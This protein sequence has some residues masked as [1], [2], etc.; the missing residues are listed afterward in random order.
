MKIGIFTSATLL[1]ITAIATPIWGASSIA[2]GDWDQGTTWDGGTPPSQAS[3]GGNG[4]EVFVNSNINV[5]TGVDFVS[6]STID[7]EGNPVD[8][9]STT[10]F[11]T[12]DAALGSSLTIQGGARVG[13]K[14]WVQITGVANATVDVL[15]GG[16]FVSSGI[17]NNDGGT[18]IVN[19]EPGG[20]LTFDSSIHPSFPDPG[21]YRG[22]INGDMAAG[23]SNVFN[24]RG[25]LD[26]SWISNATVGGGNAYNLIDGGVINEVPLSGQ[27]IGLNS[28]NPQPSGSISYNA[29]T[30]SGTGGTIT[31]AFGGAGIT[32]VPAGLTVDIADQSVFDTDISTAW[33]DWVTNNGGDPLTQ[34]GP[35]RGRISP[36]DGNTFTGSGTIQL[37]MYGFDFDDGG[38]T[39]V[40]G[41][42]SIVGIFNDQLYDGPGDPGESTFNGDFALGYVGP[43]LSDD[44][45]AFI[46]SSNPEILLINGATNNTFFDN[47][48][49]L[50]IPTQVWSDGTRQYDVT[51]TN[52]FFHDLGDPFP[53]GTP[54]TRL[55]FTTIDSITLR[56]GI[57]GD[58]DNDGD[59]DGNDFLV[60]QR[61]GS[62]NGINSGD[63]A[64]W[65]GN[66]GQGSGSL[67]SLTSIPE[68]ATISGCGIVFFLLALR[69]RS[70]RILG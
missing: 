13:T 15:S 61:G 53:P 39:G 28:G 3:N 9:I 51:F 36:T 59:V 65:Q 52:T 6:T 23:S 62:P 27:A 14:F 1:A 18:F 57:D 44:L 68:P 35:R 54:D 30:V 58:F 10:M 66:Y 46:D 41:D 67:S 47:L 8:G 5:P 43:T 17:N 49:D 69:R 63:L 32:S 70:N 26:V 12:T 50:A 11:F 64:L 29:I 40:P 19:V 7:A 55:L 34:A 42:D 33:S 37:D 20:V 24:I 4:E 21:F 25:Q 22:N 45:V 48:E 31:N 16:E 56:A 38:T 60:W 2:D